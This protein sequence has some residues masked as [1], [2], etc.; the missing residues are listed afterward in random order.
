MIYEAIARAAETPVE[1]VLAAFN[2]MKKDAR[3]AKLK[4]IRTQPAFKKAYTRL[5]A[6]R[7][8]KKAQ[9]AGPLQF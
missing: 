8:E 5:Q 7:A 3:D 4:A 1:E 6:E 2:A 9:D